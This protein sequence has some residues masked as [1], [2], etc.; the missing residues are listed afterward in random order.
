MTFSKI[1]Y[2]LQALLLVSFVSCSFDDRC[3][4]INVYYTDLRKCNL[5]LIGYP[6]TS[7]ST[8]MHG[9]SSSSGTIS[10]Y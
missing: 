9:M 1:R 10:L 2:L 3:P 7:S 6:G 8:S 4:I 5:L